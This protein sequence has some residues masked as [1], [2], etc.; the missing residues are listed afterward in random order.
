MWHAYSGRDVLQHLCRRARSLAAY[1]DASAVLICFDCR[2]FRHDLSAAYKSN[3]LEK[4]EALLKLLAVAPDRVS[5]VGQAV[6]ADGFE[7]DDCLATLADIATASEAK[8]VLASAD[9][10]LWQCL[11]DGRVG[12]VRKFE[13][14]GDAVVSQSLQWQTARELEISEKYNGLRPCS[15]ADYQ[16]LVGESGDNVAGCPGWGPAT[17]RAALAKSRS[18]EGVLANPFGSGVAQSKIIKLQAWAKNGGL[19]LARQLVTLRTDV[20]EVRE[21]L[22]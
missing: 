7:A 5:E 6:Y 16:A 9:K 10:D 17:A 21:A 19:S 3:R 2:S 12:V 20:A 4:E 1:L 13:T 18:I 15:W 22:R 14:A 11:V 8:C